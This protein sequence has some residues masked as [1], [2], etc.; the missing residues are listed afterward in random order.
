MRLKIENTDRLAQIVKDTSSMRWYLR[1]C[2]YI[3]LWLIDG[4]F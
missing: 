1:V 4:S 3:Q 2:S